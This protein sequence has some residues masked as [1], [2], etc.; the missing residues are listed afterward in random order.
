MQLTKKFTPKQDPEQTSDPCSGK[1]WIW[2]PQTMSVCTSFQNLSQETGLWSWL[3]W[4]GSVNTGTEFPPNGLWVIHKYH[5]PLMQG[6]SS[7]GMLQRCSWSKHLGGHGVRQ[8]KQAH[9]EQKTSGKPLCIRMVIWDMW[10]Q[11]LTS[12]PF[13]ANTIPCS[14]REGLH[15]QSSLQ[16]LHRQFQQLLHQRDRKTCPCSGTLVLP[17]HADDL[18]SGKGQSWTWFLTPFV[19]A[20]SCRSLPA[21]ALGKAQIRWQ[22][23]YLGSLDE[24]SWL[25]SIAEDRKISSAPAHSSTAFITG[26]LEVILFPQTS[27]SHQFCT[28]LL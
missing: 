27:L 11:T 16:R 13:G 7:T 17:C 28:F 21:V 18:G 14:S 6:H 1:V 12:L 24:V 20:S 15:S 25:I 26:P 8:D 19:N 9:T 23:G 4:K 10:E 3:S 2:T 22:T 5:N